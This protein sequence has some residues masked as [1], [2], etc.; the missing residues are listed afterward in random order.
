M[1]SRT[2]SNWSLTL[3]IWANDIMV[4][5]TIS[6]WFF[7]FSQ[8]VCISRFCWTKSYKYLPLVSRKAKWSKILRIYCST[9]YSLPLYYKISAN[10]VKLV[11]LKMKSYLTHLSPQ[12]IFLRIKIASA[13]DL[14]SSPFSFC[15][16]FFV[17]RTLNFLIVRLTISTIVFIESGWAG[18]SVLS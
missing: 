1:V 4:F 12:T 18:G 3:S 6:K 5:K 11:L 16:S 2:G 13:R 14:Y 17:E 7:L 8:M 10:S 9:S 15:I